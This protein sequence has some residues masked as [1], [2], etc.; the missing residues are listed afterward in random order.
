[1]RNPLCVSDAEQHVVTLVVPRTARDGLSVDVRGQTIV[2]SGPGFRR[3]VAM[4]PEADTAHLDAQ[5]YRD[6]LELRA[7]H[8]SD[9]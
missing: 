2:V 3:E 9:Q 8:R 1:M 6:F 7:P 5:L 4:S